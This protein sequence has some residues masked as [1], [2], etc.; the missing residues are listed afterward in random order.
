[1]QEQGSIGQQGPK[2]QHM[3]K[4]CASK[5]LRAGLKSKYL[6]VSWC[7]WLAHPSSINSLKFTS[8]TLMGDSGSKPGLAA[9]F[10]L[11]HLAVVSHFNFC[12]FIA[13]HSPIQNYYNIKNSYSDDSNLWIVSINPKKMQQCNEICFYNV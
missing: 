13:C 11:E 10:F 12:S 8:T 4:K 7:S 2:S 3:R 6:P 1:M 9:S 5:D